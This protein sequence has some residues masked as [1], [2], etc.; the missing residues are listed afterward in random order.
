M[1]LRTH[2]LLLNVLKNDFG[3]VDE[4]FYEEVKDH[5]NSF[6]AF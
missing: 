4:G 6:S 5:S 2:N 1:A 3:E